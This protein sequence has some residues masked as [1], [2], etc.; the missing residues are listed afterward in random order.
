MSER[1]TMPLK[2]NNQTE[3]ERK[4]ISLTPKLVIRHDGLPVSCELL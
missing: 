4:H 3:A 1:E 2:K